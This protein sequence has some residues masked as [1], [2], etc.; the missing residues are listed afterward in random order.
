[1]HQ[2]CLWRRATQDSTSLSCWRLIN[3][4]TLK[5]AVE[6]YIVCERPTVEVNIHIINNNLVTSEVLAICIHKIYVNAHMGCVPVSY[7]HL[8]SPRD[9]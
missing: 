7:T 3:V 4:P 6:Q 2:G 8:P 1:M 5:I 9:S